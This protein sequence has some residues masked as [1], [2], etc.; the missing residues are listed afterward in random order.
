MFEEL[1][2]DFVINFEEEKK[3]EREKN[4]NEDVDVILGHDFRVACFRGDSDAVEKFLAGPNNP[5]SEDSRGR[6]GLFYACSRIPINLKEKDVKLM[7]E[8]RVKVVKLLIEEFRFDLNKILESSGVTALFFAVDLGDIQIIKL[9]VASHRVDVNIQTKNGVTALSMAINND[10]KSEEIT[11][12]I[13]DAF[14]EH[15]WINTEIL[16]NDKTLVNTQKL[17]VGIRDKIARY[18]EDSNFFFFFFFYVLFFFLK[19]KT[20]THRTK[21]I[22]SVFESGIAQ[23]ENQV[24]TKEDMLL[25]TKLMETKKKNTLL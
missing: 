18:K 4:K 2:A 13:V 11:S 8:G 5:T 1:E 7:K 14:L 9:L 12:Q 21:Y 3:K 24:I 22:E 20:E 23:F 16:F 6:N 10:K 19:K 15:Q 25:I 17:S